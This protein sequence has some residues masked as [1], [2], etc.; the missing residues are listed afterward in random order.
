MEAELEAIKKLLKL[1]EETLIE[2]Q[3]A[4][5]KTPSLAWIALFLCLGIYFIY[6]FFTNP[7]E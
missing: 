1:N 5:R 2:L 3:K 6:A 4:N 7:I